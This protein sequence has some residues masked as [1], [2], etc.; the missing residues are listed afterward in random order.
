M[1][2][3]PWRGDLRTRGLAAARLNLRLSPAHVDTSNRCPYVDVEEC[4]HRL[5]VDRRAHHQHRI[6]NP[7]LG[8][9]LTMKA[10]CGI[11]DPLD[12]GDQRL[13]RIDEDSRDEGRP[14]VR[15]VLRFRHPTF[16]RRLTSE[17][18]CAA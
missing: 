3:A 14:A 18:S 9:T 11:E 12:E 7:K 5:A 15:D 10:P 2:R 17:L 6:S 4:W 16:A 8:W 13:R 1:R